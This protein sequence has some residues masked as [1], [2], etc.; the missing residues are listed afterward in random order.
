MRGVVEALHLDLQSRKLSDDGAT[1]ILAAAG[2][3]ANELDLITTTTQPPRED[4]QGDQPGKH[5]GHDD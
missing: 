4:N 3:V 1:R 2:H 5:K